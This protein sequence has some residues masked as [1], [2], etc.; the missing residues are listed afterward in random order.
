[1]QCC[2]V[3]PII[4]QLYP[5]DCPSA[6][7]NICDRPPSIG[8]HHPALTDLHTFP[9]L[10]IMQNYPVYPIITQ[11]YSV[12]CPS[13]TKNICDCL[14][15]IAHH[16][17]AETCFALCH[18]HLPSIGV[19]ICVCVCVCMRRAMESFLGMNI[20]RIE[21]PVT[22]CLHRDSATWPC[23]TAHSM[24]MGG[25]TYPSRLNSTAL[26]MMRKMTYTTRRNVPSFLVSSQWLRWIV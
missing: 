24:H 3:C 19:Y 15:S 16:H 7:K 10:L 8:N 22:R 18:H 20:D 2:P 23:L 5:A 13:A 6:A 21:S 9:S 1:M 26:Q 11:L 25:F 17:L 4:T 12:H 14:P